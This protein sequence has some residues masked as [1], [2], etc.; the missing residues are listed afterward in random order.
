M[1][2]TVAIVPAAGSGKRL[3]LKTK[4]PFVL[5]KGRPLVTYALKALESSRAVDG[6]IIAADK[7]S[8]KRFKS[9]VKS[10]RFKKVIDVVRGGK[11]RLESVSNCLGR[12]GNGFDVILI[13]DGARPFVDDRT[14]KDS[15]RLAAKYGA[16]VVAVPECD[17]V[18]LAGKGMFVQKTLDRSALYRTQ[19]PQ[20][21]RRD[22][23]K[24]AYSSKRRR[25]ATDDSALVE[26]LGG[27]V[28]ILE[29]SYRNIK[30]T[31]KE[32]LKLAEVLL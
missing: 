17:T 7:G 32:D 6:I 4:K 26:R 12:A 14:I 27:K 25:N 30:V 28:K 18:K 19:T 15:V 8:V 5:L 31:T 13:H 24:K 22:I 9:L 23:I 2:K 11:T 1:I 29:G 21:F 3:G 16:C 20:A 10:C